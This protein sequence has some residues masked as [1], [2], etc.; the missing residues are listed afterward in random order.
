MPASGLLAGRRQSALCPER[1]VMQV[2]PQR[3]ASIGGLVNG[4]EL[5]AFRAVVANG[6]WFSLFLP[7]AIFASP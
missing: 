6:L 3:S 1:W 5:S 2:A 7:S 4:S